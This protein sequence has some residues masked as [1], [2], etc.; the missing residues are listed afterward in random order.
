MNIS[1]KIQFI[2]DGVVSAYETMEK[3]SV[4]LI[5]ELT[6]RDPFKVLVSTIISLRTKDEVTLEASKNLFNAAFDVDSI[7]K[8]N[9]EEI[10]KLI[11]PASFFRNK[12][13]TI[14]SL[15]KTIKE[16][17]N[18]SVPNTLDELLKLKGVGR[19]T[20][21]LVLVEGFGIDAVCVDTHVHRICNRTGIVCT[22]DA[23]ATEMELRKIL[24]VKYWIKFNEM[25]V[26]YGR[27]ICRPVSPIC[28]A[29]KIEAYCD[30]N[31]VDK[32]R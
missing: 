11:Y 20:A 12:S 29:C 4:T 19:K 14:L 31:G 2:Y 3:P 7:L 16:V 18:Y 17:Y 25:L 32:R 26:S 23:D 13:V 28:S 8:L 27:E 24:P 10:E 6:H 5:S 21:N 9:N 15:A 30:K 22:K 1:E